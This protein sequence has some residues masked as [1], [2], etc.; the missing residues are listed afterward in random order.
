M[1]E[2]R[3]CPTCGKEFTAWRVDQICCS[4]SCRCKRLRKEQQ[5]IYKKRCVVC[6]RE[7]ETTNNR[8]K[9]CSDRCSGV[10]HSRRSMA[11]I[12]AQKALFEPRTCEFCGK[13]YIP[14][15]KNSRFCSKECSSKFYAQNKPKPELKYYNCEICGKDFIPSADKQKYYCKT[16]REK[17]QAR[18]KSSYKYEPD[19]KPQKEVKP[20]APNIARSLASQRWAK[21]SLREI[22]AE[23]ARFHLT[24]GRAQ[25]MAQN[26]TLPEDWGL[27]E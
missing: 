8:R 12:E 15:S 18:E 27:G 4:S 13:E 20:K 11:Y 10:A 21:M 2:N 1:K 23:C 19:K 16:C 26:G 3:I 24:Y 7:F 9:Y 5:K 14:M 17:A 6:E 25:V 22:S